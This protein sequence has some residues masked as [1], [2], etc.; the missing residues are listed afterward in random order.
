MRGKAASHQRFYL[1]EPPS[2]AGRAHF[3][4]TESKHMVA[5][6]RLAAGDLVSATDGRGQVFRIVIEEAGAERVTGLVVGVSAQPAP[7]PRIALF[8][9]VVRPVR[10]DALVEQA[11]E[12][13]VAQF[14]PV[15]CARCLRGSGQ[16]RS[17]RWKRIAVDAMKQSLGAHLMELCAPI[18]FAGAARL[19]SGPRMTLVASG[20]DA[21]PLHFG[22]FRRTRP[23]D[24]AVWVGPEGGFTDE[25]AGALRDAGATAFSLGRQ[26]LRSETAAIAAIATL[27]TCMA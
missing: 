17:G 16:G 7:E 10:M 21:E 13:A 24:L 18:A 23:A 26:R 25:E 1:A 6:L 9:A 15:L 12:L 20:P 3:D 2:K 19:A 11:A 27:R 8:Q 5:S 14:V 4:T 22:V